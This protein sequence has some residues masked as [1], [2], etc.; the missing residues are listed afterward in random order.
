MT[1]TKCTIVLLLYACVC[2]CTWV[3]LTPE[4]EQVRVL[5]QESVA[6]CERIGRIRSKTKESVA[7]IAR[8]Q[9]KVQAELEAL[10]RNDA[11]RMGGNTI[12]PL[13]PIEKGEQPFGVYRCPQQ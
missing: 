13:G 7:K 1:P 5:T 3:K 10:A 12:A 4:G 6:S 9:R 8:S 11:A 2:G